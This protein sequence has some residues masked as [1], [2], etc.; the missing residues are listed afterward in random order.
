MRFQNDNYNAQGVYNEATVVREAK[1]LWNPI[2]ASLSVRQE[3]VT[4]IKITDLKL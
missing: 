4:K 3:T 1:L 2:A